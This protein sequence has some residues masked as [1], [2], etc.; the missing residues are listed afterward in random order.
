MTPPI[1]ISEVIFAPLM[2]LIVLILFLIVVFIPRPSEEQLV[3]LI[4]SV[5][6]KEAVL[7]SIEVL[8]KQW[9]DL[10]EKRSQALKDMELDQY[11]MIDKH[12]DS[13]KAKI[14]RLININKSK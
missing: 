14:D 2:V 8:N 1:E 12:I 7:K 3:E 10:I 9:D 11:R 5:N 4:Q 6:R 13:V